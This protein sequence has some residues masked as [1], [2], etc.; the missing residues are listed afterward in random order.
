M[1]PSHNIRAR[2]VIFD[3]DG[4]LVD[5]SRDLANALTHA[6]A[7]WGGD[8]VGPEE[9]KPLVGGGLE[10]LIADALGKGATA[11]GQEDA[12]KRFVEYYEAHL[13]D[14]SLPYPAVEDTLKK[15]ANYELAVL[16]NKRSGMCEGILQ[17]LGLLKYFRVVVGG[18]A[19][20]AK[21]PHPS[22]MRYVLEALGARAAEAVMVGDSNVDI[23]AARVVQVKSIAVTHGFRPRETLLE[24]DCMVD[25]FMD[26]PAA[27]KLLGTS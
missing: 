1:P 16:S 7:P 24:A 21:K 18:D 11:E 2:Y 27:I 5:T 12:L 3:L 25:R 4:T 22:A 9:V 19:P 14:F 6:C 17:G 20:P 15:L 10:K 8:K 26:I 13:T 23:E